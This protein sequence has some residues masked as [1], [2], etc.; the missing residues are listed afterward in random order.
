MFTEISRKRSR[1]ADEVYSQ[2]L[3]AVHRGDIAPDKRIVQEQLADKLK[4]SRTPGGGPLCV[5]TGTHN[6]SRNSYISGN[7]RISVNILCCV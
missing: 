2:V 5:L 6:R 7:I 4:I 1:L 3:D